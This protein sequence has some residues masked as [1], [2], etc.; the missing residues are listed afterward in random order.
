MNN[1]IF[2]NLLHVLHRSYGLGET[3]WVLQA[4][5]RFSKGLFQTSNSKNCFSQM[6][7]NFR[8]LREVFLHHRPIYKIVLHI[9]HMFHKLEE[10]K[11]SSHGIF[12]E[13]NRFTVWVISFK[14]RSW[15]DGAESEENKTCFVGN[16]AN[17]KN[18]FHF[19]HSYHHR[20][21]AGGYLSLFF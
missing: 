9:L 1:I 4:I 7:L 3:K 20:G 16:M 13:I 8:K 12:P 6:K 10:F 5:F 2:N 18:L 15:G 19:L 17:Y 14:I 21:Y 11:I